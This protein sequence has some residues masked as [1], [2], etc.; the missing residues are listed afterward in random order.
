MSANKAAFEKQE[1]YKS[2][3]ADENKRY[4]LIGILSKR[5]VCTLVYIGLCSCASTTPQTGVPPSSPQIRQAATAIETLVA[6]SADE[7]ATSDWQFT[8]ENYTLTGQLN[9]PNNKATSKKVVL[10]IHGSGIHDRWE[11]LPSAMTLD[12]K[13][14]PIFKP[15]S[16]VFL[17]AGFVTAVFDKRGFSEIKKPSELQKILPTLDVEI[18]KKDIKAAIQSLKNMNRFDEI[19]LFGHS[20]GTILASEI[21]F[22]KEFDTFVKKL[23]LMGVAAAPMHD[24]IHFQFVTQPVNSVFATLDRNHNDRIETSGEINEYAKKPNQ[25]NLPLAM[26][27]PKQR[28]YFTREELNHVLDSQFEVI[29]SSIREAPPTQLVMGKAAGWWQEMFSR[30]PLINQAGRYRHDVVIIHGELDQQVPFAENA[31]PLVEALKRNNKSVRLLSF[32]SYGHALSPNKDDGQASLGPVQED[33]LQAIANEISRNLGRV[34]NWLDYYAK[35]IE[36]I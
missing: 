12:Q 33:V 21:D 11:T 26:L 6:D 36:M 19:Y 16:D 10:F 1:F 3:R 24:T 32:K 20:E 2:A 14:A 34:L 25:M 13:P 5:I 9:E 30:A 18:L 35:A 4:L 22:E 29:D 28:G 15:I 23:F 17:K 8:N 7:G 27:D 31:I